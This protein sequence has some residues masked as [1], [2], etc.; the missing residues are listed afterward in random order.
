MTQQTSNQDRVQESGRTPLTAEAGAHSDE[1]NEQL[2]SSPPPTPGMAEGDE[3]TVDES[4][5]DQSPGAS[6]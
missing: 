6:Q 4:L 3:E 1:G 5:R 2:T